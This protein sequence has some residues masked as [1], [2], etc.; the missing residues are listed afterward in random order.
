MNATR[1]FLAKSWYNVLACDQLQLPGP[2]NGKVTHTCR[3]DGRTYQVV[4]AL[5]KL[6]KSLWQGR[7]D[8]LH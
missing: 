5:H 8:E 2:T 7:N 6:V 3:N 1:G 4:R